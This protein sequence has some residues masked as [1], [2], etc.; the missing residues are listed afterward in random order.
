MLITDVPIVTNT[1]S[2]DTSLRLLLDFFRFVVYDFRGR[3]CFFSLGRSYAEHVDRSFVTRGKKTHRENKSVE[4]R[5]TSFKV[6]N[7]VV[8]FVQKKRK[9]LVNIY[10]DDF[11]SFLQSTEADDRSTLFILKLS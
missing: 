7:F 6:Q 8:C 4:R 10:E 5:K 9:C 2:A 3:F 1:F 11:S